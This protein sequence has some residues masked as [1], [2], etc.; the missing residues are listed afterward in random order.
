MFLLFDLETTGL[1]L[2]S[3]KTTRTSFSYEN[4]HAYDSARVVSISWMVLSDAPIFKP[5]GHQ[6]FIIRPNGYSI[7]VESIRFHGITPTHADTCGHSFDDVMAVFEEDVKRC[8]VLVSHNIEFDLNVL[9]AELYRD[10]SK[11]ADLLS[12]LSTGMQPFCTMRVGQKVMGVSKYPRLQQ[13]YEFFY[14]ESELTGAHNAYYDTLHC[15]LCF[16]QLWLGTHSQHQLVD[17]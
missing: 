2:R 3:A 8:T 5:L 9:C 11:Y 15:Y 17:T 14:P 4:T 6:Y 13:L 1:P 7:P 10:H 12:K 16:K